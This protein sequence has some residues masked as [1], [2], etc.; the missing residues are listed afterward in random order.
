MAERSAP[1]FETRPSKSTVTD[2]GTITCRSQAGLTS[3]PLL[4][5]RPFSPCAPPQKEQRRP[6]GRRYCSLPRVLRRVARR[7]VRD[8]R[9]GSFVLDCRRVGLPFAALLPGDRLGFAHQG[10]GEHLVHA[11]DRDDLEAALDGL[12]DVHEVLGVL[13]GDQHCF[14]AAAERREGLLLQTADR[15]HPAAQRDLAGHPTSRRTGM[16]VSTETMALAMATPADGPSFGRAA[17]GDVHVD[18]APVEQRRLDAEGDRARAH[19]GRRRPGHLPKGRA[20]RGS[21]SFRRSGGQE[22]RLRRDCAPDRDCVTSHPGRADGVTALVSLQAETLARNCARLISARSRS[23]MMRGSI[24]HTMPRLGSS[25][26]SP[27]AALASYS[28]E[29]Q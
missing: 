3:V 9:R 17:F 23:L 11:G 22:R 19:I 20:H 4:R 7:S 5:T 10:A 29:M 24:G 12:W 16:P 13:L 27:V 25:H 6:E 28:A 2:F 14:H 1:S 15:Q 26:R 18:V 21:R 8:Q